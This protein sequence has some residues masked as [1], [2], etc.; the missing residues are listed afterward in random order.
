MLSASILLVVAAVAHGAMVPMTNILRPDTTLRFPN[1]VPFE[2]L[3]ED[4]KVVH[5]RTYEE[6]EE[7]QRKE[8]FRNNL[9]KIEMHNYLHAQGKSSYTLGINQFA[10]LEAN[11]FASIMNGFRMNKNRTQVRDHL[12]S[13]YIS[14]AIPVSIPNEVDWTKEGYVT[15]IKNQGRCG[16]CWSFSTTGSLEGQHFRKTGKL[17][18][19]SE[20]NLVDCSKAYGNNGCNGG[21]MDYAFK[22]IQVNDGDDTEESYPYEG[23]DGECR[24]KKDFVGA[25]VTGY[26]DLPK[27]DELKMKEAVATIGPIAVAIDA[28]HQSF[29]MYAS[30]VYDEETCTDN[31]DHAVLVVGYGTDLGQDYWLVKN[32]WGTTWGDDGYIKM[33]RNKDNQ[34]GIANMASYPLV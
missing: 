24:F 13:N 22:Y 3:W 33:S 5:E 4:F 16:S 10:D 20:Q 25:T 31:L 21:V 32:S 8:V 34:C 6:N 11:E 1:Q 26:T 9:K 17:V 19:L 29:Q 12:H 14:P 23:V 2:K 27:G 28:A 30:G 18:S 15:P 7:T